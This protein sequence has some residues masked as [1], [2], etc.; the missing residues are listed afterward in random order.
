MQVGVVQRPVVG[1]CL[2]VK[3]N[4]MLLPKGHSIV[5]PDEELVSANSTV[6]PLKDC[7]RGTSR[8]GC[9]FRDNLPRYSFPFLRGYDGNLRP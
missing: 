5:A 4:A 3:I 7:S 2:A 6:Q 9:S 8:L 1:S